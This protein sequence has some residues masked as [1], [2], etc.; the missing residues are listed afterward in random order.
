MSYREPPTAPLAPLGPVAT[1][2]QPTAPVRRR[3]RWG[4]SL[5]DAFDPRANSVNALRLF[6][7][8]LVLVSHT[9]KLHG[10]EDP[11]G[12]FTGGFVDLGTMAVDGFFALSGFLIVGSHLASPSTGRY[13]WRRALRI[14]PGFWV[15]L[16]VTAFV[17]LPIA[18]LLQHGTLAGFPLTGE[19]SALSYVTHNAALFV[20]QFEVTGLLGGEAV[21]GSLYTLFYEFLCYLGIAA[22]GAA[23]LLRRGAVPLLV[24]AGLLWAF[25]LWQFLDGGSLVGRSSTLEIALRF[26]IMFVAGALA[27]RVAGVLPLGPVGGVL[28]TVLL[29]WAV[30]LA[31]LVGEDPRG[32]LAYAVL[33]PPAVAYLVLLAGSSPRLRRIGSRRDLSYGLYVYAWPVQVLLLLAGAAAW[34]VLLY[35]AASLGAVL[36]LAWA[37]WTWVEAPAL[38]LKSWSP[39]SGASRRGSHRSR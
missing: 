15:C 4:P 13:L 23:G 27:H 11:I 25:A 22:L 14:L 12:R 32:T 31:V 37:S 10:G 35:G 8:G 30:A 1:D 18:Q 17:L 39:G 5:A 29:V 16:L 36:L 24:V 2:E 34:P 7:A 20:R 33:A 6:L 38:R 3:G 19:A 9:L 28:A 26:G 21:N